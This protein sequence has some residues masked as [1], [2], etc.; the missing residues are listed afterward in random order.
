M[1]M[2][3]L[4]PGHLAAGLI[5]PFIQPYS[6]YIKRSSSGPVLFSIIFANPLPLRSLEKYYN[7]NLEIYYKINIKINLIIRINKFI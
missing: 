5:N 3:S 2:P 4:S 6:A 7:L 1:A